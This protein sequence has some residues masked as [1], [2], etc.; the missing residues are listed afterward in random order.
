MAQALADRRQLGVGLAERHAPAHGRDLDRHATLPDERTRLPRCALG[1]WHTG[2]VHLARSSPA[3]GCRGGFA[4]TG[5]AAP[6]QQR[7]PGGDSRTCPASAHP[8]ASLAALGPNGSSGVGAPRIQWPCGALRFWHA[9]AHIHA[10]LLQRRF[11]PLDGF[12][13][14]VVGSGLAVLDEIL[15][16][17]RRGAPRG[18]TRPVRPRLRARSRACAWRPGGGC[19]SRRRGSTWRPARSRRRPPR[20]QCSTPR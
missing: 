2:R 16:C 19:A 17:L 6:G 3:R 13:L 12:F 5:S 1:H 9:A 14:R 10:R 15:Q 8:P 7:D 11:N 4:A 20:R 18:V